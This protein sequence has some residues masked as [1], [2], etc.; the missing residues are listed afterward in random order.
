MTY[1]SHL[2]FTQLS[3]HGKLA[4]I[5]RMPAVALSTVFKAG[6]QVAPR[7]AVVKTQLNHNIITTTLGHIKAA[8]TVR[9]LSTSQIAK[10]LGVGNVGERYPLHNILPQSLNNVSDSILNK[11]PSTSLVLFLSQLSITSASVLC[12]DTYTTDLPHA[13]VDINVFRSDEQWAVC[14]L[15][16]PAVALPEQVEENQ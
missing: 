14:W 2:A 11:C 7:L 5:H 10:L 6:E 8:R 16:D 12:I 13:C 3:L 15:I 9:V 1:T 4:L